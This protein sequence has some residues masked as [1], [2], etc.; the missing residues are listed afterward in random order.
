MRRR[1][2]RWGGRGRGGLGR[3]LEL[4]RDIKGLGL[5]DLRA[6]ESV[7]GAPDSVELGLARREG[8]STVVVVAA[9]RDGLDLT[10]WGEVALMLG[11]DA[12]G[13]SEVV[14][15]APALADSTRRAAERASRR[16]RTFHLV[17]ASALADPKEEILDQYVYPEPSL[18]PL[19]AGGSASVLERVLT[20]VAGAGAAGSC[21]EVRLHG[22]AALLYMRGTAVL[23]VVPAGEGASLE[24]LFPDPR[25]V[26]VTDSN[27]SRWGLELHET[28]LQLAQDPRLVEA[29]NA[30]REAAI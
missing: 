2:G 28:I 21:G 5:R 18:S 19:R 8:G 9:S 25:L 26:H 12:A 11:S 14:I 30:Q 7:S 16:G 22:S 1:G 13:L 20:V 10:G 6:L 3:L 15:V 4:V 23:R 24:F 27:F 17:V 29:D